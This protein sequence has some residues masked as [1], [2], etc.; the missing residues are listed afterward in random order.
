M[1]SLGNVNLEKSCKSY[2][3]KQKYHQACWPLWLD[4]YAG[5]KSTSYASL[6]IWRSYPTLLSRQVHH[7]KSGL[8]PLFGFVLYCR[9]VRRYVKL[10]MQDYYQMVL[11]HVSKEH[12]L[13]ICSEQICLVCTGHQLPLKNRQTRFI[14]ISFPI[15]AEKGSFTII[16]QPFFVKMFWK[17]SE[18]PVPRRRVDQRLTIDVWKT[19]EPDYD[20][21]LH[22][23]WNHSFLDI[24]FI[25][26][27]N[28]LTS[29]VFIA[30]GGL[31]IHFSPMYMSP[32]AS[33]QTQHPGGQCPR[34][35]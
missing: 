32:S 33:D 19:T 14:L 8:N 30:V 28:V 27:Q 34:W 22:L 15:Q 5:S 24:L 13:F 17:T 2:I 6:N 23:D 1:S 29:P 20:L 25:L 10:M 18:R 16:C 3:L 12:N 4:S 26:S 9:S 11:D 21:E 31:A 7:S 35:R